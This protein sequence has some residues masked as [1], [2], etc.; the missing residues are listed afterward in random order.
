MQLSDFKIS[1]RLIVAFLI[2]ALIGG[3]AGFF[4]IAQM[5]RLNAASAT[6]YDRDLVGLSEIKEANTQL[7]ASGRAART[8]LLATTKSRRETNLK[9][10]RTALEAAKVSIEKAEPLVTDEQGRELIKKLKEQWATYQTV[11]GK[12]EE[13]IRAQAL[14]E[15]N[16][17]LEYMFG[18]GAVTIVEMQKALAELSKTKEEMSKE[19][20]DANEALYVNARNLTMLMI[21]VALGVGVGLG[22][23]ISRSVVTPLSKAR[24]AAQFM[25]DGDMS[26]ELPRSGRDEVGDVLHALEDMRTKLRGIVTTVRA[27]AETVATASSEIAQGNTNL[28]QRTEEQASALEETAATMDELASTVRNNAD[29]AQQANQLALSASNVAVTGGEVVGQV[30]ETMRGINDSSKKIADIIGVI[31]GIAFQTNILALNAAVEAARAGEQGRGFAVVAAEVR[32]LAGRSA[33][34]AKEIKSLISASVERVELGTAQVDKAGATMTE[35]VGAIR[36]VTDIVGEISSASKEQSA[37]IGQVGDAIQQMDKVTQ[38]N[39]ALVEEGAAAAMS[40][41]DQAQS[42]VAAVAGFKLSSGERSVGLSSAKV[43]PS[44]SSSAPS[45]TGKSSYTPPAPKTSSAAPAPKPATASSPAA[46]APRPVAATTAAPK[47]A[48]APAV[49]AATSDTDEWETF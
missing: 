32:S 39:A 11:N 33:D 27:N 7:L 15:T 5:S 21:V 49:A 25:A 31:D 24:E 37:G 42:L 43:Q 2:V 9:N 28:S 48:P 19:T 14:T 45:K 6:L 35:I 30:V 34:A 23:V 22:F 17:A 40:L 20:H 12:L 3:L 36:R 47:A 18:E 10:V 44:S 26:Q 46:A 1:A 41:R 8:A 16:D 29:N 13:L 4:A 38:Q